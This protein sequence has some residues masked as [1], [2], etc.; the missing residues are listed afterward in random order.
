MFGE[1]HIDH[2]QLPSDFCWLHRLQFPVACS[3][4]ESSHGFEKHSTAPSSSYISLHI[5]YMSRKRFTISRDWI[6]IR[7]TPG[8]EGKEV[9]QPLVI[10]THST[11][12]ELKDVLPPSSRC[13]EGRLHLIVGNVPATLVFCHAFNKHGLDFCIRTISFPCW[14]LLDQPPTPTICALIQLPFASRA[15]RQVGGKKEEWSQAL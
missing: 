6:P 10:C 2:L 12:E 11:S 4:Y 3:T 5:T 13:A 8:G 15:V 7:W 9:K 14:S 1:G